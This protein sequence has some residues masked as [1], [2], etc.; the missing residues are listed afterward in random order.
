MS[1]FLLV[2]PWVTALVIILALA[3]PELLNYQRVAVIV[4][5]INLA[6]NLKTLKP[7][8]TIPRSIKFANKHLK[9]SI[10]NKD[11]PDQAK[12]PIQTIGNKVAPYSRRVCWLIHRIQ[13]GCKN[14]HGVSC[15][16]YVSTDWIDVY[17]L[18]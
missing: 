9:H 4:Q 18:V 12:V 15:W 3:E 14:V 6:D 10:H 1:S 16:R 8:S 17:A 5:T 2:S 13:R 11:K 7:T